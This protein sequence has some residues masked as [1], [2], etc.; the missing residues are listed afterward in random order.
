MLC[1]GNGQKTAAFIAY[2]QLE[3][4]VFI[5]HF[6][7]SQALRG[8]GIGANFMREFLSFINMPVILEVEPPDTQAAIRRIEF[9]KR[10]GF[11]HNR[12]EYMQPP[13]R[14]Q[15][16]YIRLD[17]M[18]CPQSFTKNEFLPLKNKIYKLVYGADV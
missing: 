4:F 9:Y 18:S 3:G 14:E 13:M 1:R 2:W 7:V 8:G 16:D 15:F 12:F 11:K 17:I 6:A 10:L 5:E